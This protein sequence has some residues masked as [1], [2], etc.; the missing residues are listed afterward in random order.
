[1]QNDRVGQTQG[2]PDETERDGRIQDH[3]SGTD[4][5]GEVADPAGKDGVGEQNRLPRALDAKGLAA[6][7]ALG[8]GIRTGQDGDVFGGQAAPQLPEV[9]LYAADLGREVVGDK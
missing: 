7:E 4:V 6:V 1:V 5:G 9:R 8:V 3:Q 2:R